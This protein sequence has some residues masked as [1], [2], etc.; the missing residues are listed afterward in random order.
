MLRTAKYVVI[1]HYK[2]SISKIEF[3]GKGLSD[4]VLSFIL[5][6]SYK[7]KFLKIPIRVV[8]LGHGLSLQSDHLSAVRL[9]IHE[10]MSLL[11]VSFL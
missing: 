4:S 10:H 6:R 1:I 9:E 7:R 3:S 2:L 8:L 11:W 5:V